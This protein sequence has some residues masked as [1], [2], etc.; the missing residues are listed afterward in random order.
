MDSLV[1]AHNLA[2]YDF[3]LDGDLDVLTGVNRSRAVNLNR[4]DFPMYILLNQAP[5][6]DTLRLADDGTYNARVADYEGDGDWDIFRYP[7]HDDTT[8][9]VWINQVIANPSE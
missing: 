1:A 9:Q 8:Y 5:G 4:D 2:V 6:W 3:D 7:T